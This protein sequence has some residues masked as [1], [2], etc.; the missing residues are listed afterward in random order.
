MVEFITEYSNVV[1]RD[2]F[3]R[4]VKK[5]YLFKSW[6]A[7]SIFSSIDSVGYL[8]FSK[9]ISRDFIKG[10]VKNI[11]IIKNDF[12]GDLVLSTSFFRE[13][14]ENFPEARICLACRLFSKDI[15]EKN[16]FVDEVIYF[17]TPW[18]SRN[19]S[20]GYLNVLKFIYKSFRAYD[21]VFDLTIDPRNVLV[22]FFVG[23]FRVGFKNRGVGFLL[24]KGLERDLRNHIV[25]ENLR[26]LKALN[27]KVKD[28]RLDLS[29]LVDDDFFSSLELSKNRYIVIHPGVSAPSRD[30]GVENFVSLAKRL[31]EKYSVVIVE[32]ENW[33]LSRFK[34]ISKVK[35]VKTRNIIELISIIAN[36]KM[37]IGL[38]SLSIHLAASLGV[39]VI[40]IH[41]GT[42][43][44]WIMGPY[45]ND[46]I[47]LFNNVDCVFCGK[48]YCENNLCMKGIKVKDVLNAVDLLLK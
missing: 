33:I 32:R 44:F 16:P 8:V 18:F 13:L 43:P 35:V 25:E 6:L 17:N 22:S 45:T 26:L 14:R 41:S 7:K 10:S 20:Q 23:K 40:D 4:F 15:A 28:H 31:S 12:I 5:K 36:S 37:L 29:Y 46:K 19:D 2:Y 11:L 39:R 3:R 30:W 1:D 21:L 47:V 34:G 38:E 27:L 48:T 24:S 9:L 42:T